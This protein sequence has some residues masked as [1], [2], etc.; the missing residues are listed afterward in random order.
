MT[1]LR[2]EKHKRERKRD[3]DFTANM[4][5]CDYTKI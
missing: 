3:R 4:R 2:H 5:T 1:V